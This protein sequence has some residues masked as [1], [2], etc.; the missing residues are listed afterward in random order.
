MRVP[1]SNRY[2]LVRLIRLLGAISDN[3]AITRMPAN[4][5]A[6]VFAPSMLRHSDPMRSLNGLK[7]G[8]V[9]VARLIAERAEIFGEFAARHPPQVETLFFFCLM[10]GLLNL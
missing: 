9:V 2:A 4:N 1:A 3:A 8:I 7:D 5:L 10:L 6:T